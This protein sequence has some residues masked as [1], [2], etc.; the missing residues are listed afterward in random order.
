MKK[1]LVFGVFD[2]VHEGHRALFREAKRH[3]DH[4]VLAVARDGVIEKLKRRA[5]DKDLAA[6]IAMLEKELFVDEAVPGDEV[7]GG[8]GV[9]KAHRPE[10]VALGYDQS[11]LKED[12]ESKKAMFDW[13]FEILVMQPHEPEKYHNSL[14][15][16]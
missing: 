10:V 2:G 15:K 5:P 9:I 11:A 3:G 6:R 7:L 13:D 12:L 1:V 16:K 4:L 8:Y 14:L